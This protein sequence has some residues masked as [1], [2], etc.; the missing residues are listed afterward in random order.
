MLLVVLLVMKPVTTIPSLGIVALVGSVGFE[1]QSRSHEPYP[2]VGETVRPS[3]WATVG[4]WVTIS[5]ITA[6]RCCLVY[7]A[8]CRDGVC[9]VCGDSC[10]L[11]PSGVSG[12]CLPLSE[13]MY[14]MELDL[15]PFLPGLGRRRGRAALRCV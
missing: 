6:W 15:S 3:R 7:A 1:S 9:Q 5:V 13:Q 4:R 8:W 12:A 14:L 2:I 10:P 11:S